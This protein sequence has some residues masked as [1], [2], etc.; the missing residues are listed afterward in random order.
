MKSKFLAFAVLHFLIASNAFSDSWTSGTQKI[1]SAAITRVGV[2]NASPAAQLDVLANT[3]SR[4]AFIVN[5]VQ[6]TNIARFK[7]NGSTK[8]IVN[9]SG[10]VGVNTSSPSRNL[11]VSGTFRAGSIEG[12]G[13]FPVTNYGAK[14]NNTGADYTAQFQAA[15][16]AAAAVSGTVFVPGGRYTIAGTL[17]IPSNVTLAG[18]TFGQTNDV[19]QGSILQTAS[20][21]GATNG[22]TFIRMDPHSK[23]RGITVFYPHQVDMA[24]ILPYP[25][26]LTLTHANEVED[27]ILVNSYQGILAKLG[28]ERHLIRNVGMTAL[29]QGIVLAF[30]NGGAL[31]NVRIGAEYAQA[32]ASGDVAAYTRSNAEALVFQTARHE[33]VRGCRITDAMFALHFQAGS[34]DGQP[35]L[36]NPGVKISDLATDNCQ[37]AVFA[38]DVD[39]NDGLQIDNSELHGFFVINSGVTGPIKIANTSFQVGFT[40]QSDILYQNGS[41]LLMLSNCHF[42]KVGVNNVL[43]HAML[44]SDGRTVA[45]NI[46]F[47]PNSGAEEALFLSTGSAQIIL[48]N[49][50]LNGNSTEGTATTRYHPSNVIP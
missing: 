46:D 21:E 36:P 5:Q 12:N 22:T 7:L 39:V 14:A 37:W 1:T 42:G 35:S 49:A 47:A 10:N 41:G 18:T 31:D 24:S 23:L 16:N 38:D 32:K 33:T 45:S 27:V 6:P 34:S 29:N 4:E 26:T 17:F 28:S 11:D 3:A 2:G 25:F 44:L 15:L 40:G 43:G 30:S 48:A 19:D 20:G 13:V 50:F 8:L 9:G